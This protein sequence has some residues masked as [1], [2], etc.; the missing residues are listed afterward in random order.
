MFISATLKAFY[1]SK[2]CELHGYNGADIYLMKDSTVTV[3]R[4]R[5]HVLKAQTTDVQPITEDTN[6][7]EQ[8]PSKTLTKGSEM[9]K[10][11]SWQ[12]HGNRREEILL[13][14]EGDSRGY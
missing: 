2:F 7:I 6:G 4:S 8:L 11:I 13:I 12:Y 1:N 5:Q 14:V 3:E 9:F 10:I